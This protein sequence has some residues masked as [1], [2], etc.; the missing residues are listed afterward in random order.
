M[1]PDVEKQFRKAAEIQREIEQLIASGFYREATGR[2][3]LAMLNAASAVFLAKEVQSGFRQ[4]LVDKFSS[5]FVETGLLDK[6]FHNYFSFAYNARADSSSPSFSSCD[7]RLAQSTLVK[8]KEFI[9]A[10]RKLAE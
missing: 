4:T 6:K 1:K 5:T 8:V 7:H 3:Y 2:A 9:E 10:C